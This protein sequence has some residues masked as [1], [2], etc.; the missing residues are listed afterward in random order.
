MQVCPV[1][2]TEVSELESS[3]PA[4]GFKLAGSTQSFKPISLD[5]QD[6]VAVADE[7]RASLRVARGPQIGTV[8]YLGDGTKKIGRNPQCD[9]FLNDMTVSRLHA[10][11]KKKGNQYRIIDKNSF[12]GLWVNNEEISEETVLSQGDVVQI[13]V[14]CLVFEL[15]K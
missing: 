15:V 3:C 8:Y 12:N 11:I 9:I 4:C 1:C 14:F 5:D 13:G 6:T 7:M 10:V 2:S